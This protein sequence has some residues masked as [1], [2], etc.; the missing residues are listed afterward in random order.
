MRES[1]TGGGVLLLVLSAALLLSGLRPGSILAASEAELPGDQLRLGRIAVGRPS[2]TSAPGTVRF[3]TDV[4]YRLVTVQSGLLVMFVFE[5]NSTRS[6][7]QN[8]GAIPIVA[9]SGRVGLEIEYLPGPD[10]KM[11]TLFIGLFDEQQRLLSWLSTN[12]ITVADWA[13]RYEFEESIVARLEGNH[14]AAIDRLSRAIKLSPDTGNLYYWRADARVHLR[15]YDE[16]IKDYTTALELL[17]HHRASRLGR[18]VAWLWK[19]EWQVAHDDLTATLEMSSDEDMVAAW[20][21]RARGIARIGLGETADAVADY[22]TYLSLA[23]D[24]PGRVEVEELLADLHAAK[25]GGP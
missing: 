9:G 12:P 17:P 19:E 4:D 23:P 25:T 13:G 8:S 24:D 20:A 6:S 3:E 2:P 10:I 14:E 7:Q 11:L 22:E 21:H 18:G 5:E 1:V 15:D 16:A